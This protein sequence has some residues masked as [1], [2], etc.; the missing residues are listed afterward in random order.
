[1]PRNVM[2]LSSTETEFLSAMAARGRSGFTVDEAK[3]HWDGDPQ[4]SKRLAR[5]AEKGW[6]ERLERGKYM[7]VPLE[8]GPDRQWTEDAYVL[9]GYLVD[10]AAI[11]Y[12]SALHY[13]NLTEQVPRLA[14]VQTTADVREHRKEVLGIRFRLVKLKEEKFFGLEHEQLGNQRFAVTRPEK[15]ILDG[16]DRPDLTGGIREVAKGLREGREELDWSLVEEYLP[17]LGS[18]A[19]VKR[20]GY[21]V[22]A[23]EIDVPNRSARLSRWQEMTSA[24]ISA[25]DPSSRQEEGRIITRWGI[26]INIEEDSLRVE[27]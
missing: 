7:I 15:T 23:M 12:W 1:M 4:T 11:A 2:S 16:L 21:L 6:L 18:G 19:V 13:W 8:A 5:L 10:P 17:R 25:L 3:E 9:A 14:Y 22:E 20:L 24:G 26:R 27:K